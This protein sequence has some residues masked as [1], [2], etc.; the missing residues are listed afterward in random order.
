MLG[1][2][3]VVTGL[4][5]YTALPTYTSL[6]SA[7]SLTRGLAPPRANLGVELVH[8]LSPSGGAADDNKLHHD[9]RE[10]AGHDGAPHHLPP[11]TSL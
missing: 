8:L 1:G 11:A 2:T 3:V 4:P 7:S 5:I 10:A 9:K 6:P